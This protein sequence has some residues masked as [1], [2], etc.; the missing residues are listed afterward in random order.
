MHVTSILLSPPEV[1][2][3]SLKGMIDHG[4][5]GSLHLELVSLLARGYTRIVLDCTKATVICSMAYGAI[6]QVTDR[7]R[8]AGGD[9]RLVGINDHMHRIL[10]V[11]MIVDWLTFC[12]DVD[13]AVASFRPTPD[14]EDTL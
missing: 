5:A 3:I 12:K 6:C 10:E 11:L 8:K 1:A 7:C 2:I 9:L 13:A 14:L 4:T